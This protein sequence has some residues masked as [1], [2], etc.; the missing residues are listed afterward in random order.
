[1]TVLRF[2]AHGPDGAHC[3]FDGGGLAGKTGQTN[4]KW[5][6]SQSADGEDTRSAPVS[7]N[8]WF[9]LSVSHTSPPI[10]E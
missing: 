1:M 7:K 8:Q 5:N 10:V 3:R 6:G 2:A 4:K 9:R